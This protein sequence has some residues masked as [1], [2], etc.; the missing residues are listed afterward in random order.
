MPLFT[1]RHALSIASGMQQDARARASDE[2]CQSTVS[3]LVATRGWQAFDELV[4]CIKAG[5]DA[6]ELA[7]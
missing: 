3:R 2:A 4:R 6:F 5:R 7:F 1:R